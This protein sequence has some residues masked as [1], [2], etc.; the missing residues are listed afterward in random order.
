[1]EKRVHSK[2]CRAAAMSQGIIRVD[3]GGVI[4]IGMS[5]GDDEVSDFVRH[6]VEDLRPDTSHDIDAVG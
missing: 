3:H 2:G 6:G 1:M 4:L 5:T